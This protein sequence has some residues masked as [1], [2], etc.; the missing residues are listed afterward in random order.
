MYFREYSGDP[1]RPHHQPAGAALGRLE[2]TEGRYRFRTYLAAVNRCRKSVV[3]LAESHWTIVWE[4]TYDFDS[5][6]WAPVD[7]DAVL[8][9]QEYDQAAKYEDLTSGS[10][11]PPFSLFME[12][13]K[14]SWEVL[15]D[16]VWVPC[17]DCYPTR[18]EAD[19]PTLT[20]W[21]S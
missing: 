18:D 20:T 5:K 1:A 14:K 4:G 8:T 3:T 6:M 9:H 15:V 12:K 11:A 2:R 13:A 7:A 16:G 10:P 17:K 19:K 21:L